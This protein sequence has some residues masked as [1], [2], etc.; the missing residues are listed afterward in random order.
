[1]A[2]GKKV[3]RHASALKARRQSLARRIKNVQVRSKVRTLTSSV[4]KAIEAKNAEVA[5]SAFRTA[6]AAWAKAAKQGV[7]T[8]NAASRKISRLASRLAAIA[9]A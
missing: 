9:K 1:M 3:M 8:K 4:L 7:F 5:K 6:Q 2:K